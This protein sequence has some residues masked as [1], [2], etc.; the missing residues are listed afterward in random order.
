M[1]L[2]SLPVLAAALLGLSAG[3]V[4][5]QERIGV[6]LD[7]FS[8]SS[9][10]SGDQSINASRLDES[11]DYGARGG[12]FSAWL[13]YAQKPGDHLRAGPGIRIFG[14][15]GSGENPDF[16]FGFLTEAFMMGEYS[17]H[18][19]EKFDAIFGGRA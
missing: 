11:F 9:S 18:A 19:I 17:V 4:L 1:R 2:R 13:L 5:A 8:E 3:P 16:I 15:Y 10:M 14:N 12:A 6:G 7:L